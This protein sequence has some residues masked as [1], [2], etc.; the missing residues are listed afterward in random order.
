MIIKEIVKSILKTF[1][2]F[3]LVRR[4]Y[5]YLKGITVGKHIVSLI[6]S[7]YANSECSDDEQ[8]FINFLKANED[9]ISRMF[10]GTNIYLFI[11]A[12]DF[13]YDYFNKNYEVHFFE[14]MPYLDYRGKK[15]FMPVEWTIPQMV[16][17]VRG[18]DIEQDSRSP[19]CYFP[20]KVNLD[21]K[22]LV[23][24][25]GAEGNFAIEFIEQIKFLYIFE[26]DKKWMKPLNYTY[27]KWNSKVKIIEHLVGDGTNNT[28]KL[29]DCF[30]ECDQID[31]I[32]MDVE[33]FEKDVIIGA[34]NI[35][36]K[37]KKLILL[38]CVYHY[39]KQ[40]RDVVN[41]LKDYKLEFRKGRMW[42]PN[43]KD[44]SNKLLRH[45]LLEA[46]K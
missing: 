18:I 32:K 19:H 12:N 1:H 44:H 34:A 30:S 40:E 2:L 39:D 20:E 4:I 14:D 42:F 10:N 45:C 46:S 8:S 5:L 11:F 6:I 31:Y 35:L 33:G 9:K 37:F 25:G 43:L 38:V 7:Q 29:D 16:N 23:D 13:V 21:N 27:R 26:T 3:N 22:V 36:S 41:L 28:I 17:Y 24:V 15:L